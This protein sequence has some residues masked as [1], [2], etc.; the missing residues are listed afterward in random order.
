ME[1]VYR[2]EHFYIIANYHKDPE[3]RVSRRICQYLEQHGKQCSIQSGDSSCSSGYTDEK[4]IPEDVDCILVLGGDGTLLQAAR[5]TLFRGIP[6]L[7][8][9][10]GTLGYLADVEECDIEEALSLLLE[11]AYEIEQRMMLSGRILPAADKIRDDHPETEILS[12]K[13]HALNDIVITRCGTLQI[14]RFRIWVNGQVLN[15]YEADGVIIAT[16]TGSTG[17]NLSAGGP[18]VEPRAEM[19]LITPVCPHTLNTR[20]IILAP[21]DVIEIEI[22]PGRDNT[23]QKVEVDFDGSNRQILSSGDRVEIRRADRKTGIV[24]INKISFLEIL[25]RKLSNGCKRKE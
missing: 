22:A 13:M 2:M 21:E 18:I 8:I 17:Y 1:H 5:E 20:T 25:H 16:P 4:N 6:L 10:L 15:E 12:S 3:H 19:L 9:N 24:K 11:G 14:I 7:G 23:I